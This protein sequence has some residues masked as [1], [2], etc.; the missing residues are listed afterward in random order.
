MRGVLADHVRLVLDPVGHVDAALGGRPVPSMAMAAHAAIPAVRYIRRERVNW[1]DSGHPSE[2][3]E[4]DAGDSNR[5]GACC[6]QRDG[7]ASAK[8]TTSRYTLSAASFPCLRDKRAAT[9]FSQIRCPL[10][11]ARV[12]EAG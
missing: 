6:K 12:R 3:A 4:R 5:G 8:Q 11:L 10:Q 9:R 1:V 2:H 7:V